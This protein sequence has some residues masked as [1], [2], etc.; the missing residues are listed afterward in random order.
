MPDDAEVVREASIE[1]D[2][3]SVAPDDTT[4]NARAEQDRDLVVWYWF[5][6]RSA[7]Y[8]AY[9]FGVVLGLVLGALLMW[10]T[11]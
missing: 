8:V 7:L 6:V 10:V 5:E 9:G 11:A 3:T 1:L 2:R 4:T